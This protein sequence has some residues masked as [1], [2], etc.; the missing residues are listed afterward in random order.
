MT[1]QFSPRFTFDDAERA[2][3]EWGA[4]CG[5]GAL[6]AVAGLSLDEIR[7]RM[8]DFERKGYTNPKL[9]FEC[10]NGLGLRWSAIKPPDW[11]NFGLVRVQW[12][13]PWTEPGVPIRAR[14]RYTHW[15]AGA[16]LNGN[17][18]VFDINC[19]NNGSG[20]VAFEEW[21]SVIVP[22]LVKHHAKRGTGKWHLTH[23]VEVLDSREA[24]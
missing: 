21:E 5:P 6:A 10:L 3:K 13:G 24:D 14:Y 8:G 4:N 12:E 2:W 23:A 22:H 19:I 20:W 1:N 9:M 15:V 11:P 18:G 17:I 7:P 16:R